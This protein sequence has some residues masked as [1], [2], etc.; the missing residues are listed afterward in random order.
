MQHNGS[1]PDFPLKNQSSKTKKS[2]KKFGLL[3]KKGSDDLNDLSPINPG[4]LNLQRSSLIPVEGSARYQRSPDFEKQVEMMVEEL[5]QKR[6]DYVRLLKEQKQGQTQGQVQGQVKIP[7]K[8]EESQAQAEGSEDEQTTSNKDGKWRTIRHAKAPSRL[9]TGQDLARSRSGEDGT[10]SSATSD[11][12]SRSSKE[13]TVRSNVDEGSSFAP[14]FDVT[15]LNKRNTSPFLKSSPTTEIKKSRLSRSKKREELHYDASA[16]DDTSDP[17]NSLLTADRKFN[18]PGPSLS[19]KPLDREE[20]TLDAPKLRRSKA[21]IGFRRDSLGIDTG[22]VS[23]SPLSPF[24]CSASDGMEH[25]LRPKRKEKPPSIITSE[26]TS[27]VPTAGKGITPFY[28]SSIEE[29]TALS[30]SLA[31]F[32]SSDEVLPEGSETMSAEGSGSSS[33]S[34]L[35]KSHQR[36]NKSLTKVR[37]FKVNEFDRAADSKSTSVALSPFYTDT[38]PIPPSDNDFAHPVTSTTPKKKRAPHFCKEKTSLHSEV[39][40]EF[41]TQAPIS[42][43]V[44]RHE[45]K[46]RVSKGKKAAHRFNTSDTLYWVPLL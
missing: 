36:K 12:I 20:C 4:N 39:P 3:R 7:P 38:D 8:Q 28:S 35:S 37:H 46:A 31:P 27:A 40:T 23:G 19:S 25:S 5:L 15:K 6:W 18:S 2:K 44:A 21:E 10:R 34:S 17:D 26:K 42:R 33:N 32:Y 43:E 45:K 30:S 24:Y 41:E 29:S 11:G 9:G 1:I 22:D 13:P 16:L 14:S